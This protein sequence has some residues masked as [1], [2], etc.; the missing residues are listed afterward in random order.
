MSTVDWEC[1]HK[2]ALTHGAERGTT[3]AG[4]ALRWRTI[5]CGWALAELNA[6]NL[7]VRG[8]PVWDDADNREPFLSKGCRF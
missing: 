3:A 7:E 4:F 8:R 2:V 6:I 5:K 1:H